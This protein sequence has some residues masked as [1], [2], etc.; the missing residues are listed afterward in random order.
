VEHFLERQPSTAERYSSYTR[1]YGQDGNPPAPHKTKE[2]PEDGNSDPDPPSISLLEFESYVDI[3]S[4]IEIN[5][6]QKR[7][8]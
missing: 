2:E 5:K 6:A 1:G 3:L 4:S 8:R 7:Q